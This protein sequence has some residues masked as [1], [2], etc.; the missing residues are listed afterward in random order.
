MDTHHHLVVEIGPDK[1]LTIAVPPQGLRVG[2]SA[3]NDV[4]L[5]DPVMSRFHCRFFFKPGE[6]LWA[7][8]L[9]SANQTLL[10]QAP[11]HAS[12]LRVG[13]RL[14]MGDTT[15]RVMSETSDQQAARALFDAPGGRKGPGK[16]MFRRPAEDREAG[17]HPV[18]ASLLT[19]LF[20]VAALGAGAFVWLRLDAPRPAAPHPVASV[21]GPRSNTL[22]VLYEKVQADDKT[23]FRYYLEL[24]NGELSIQVHD[25]KNQRQVPGRQRRPV[26]AELVDQLGDAIEAADFFSLND[27]YEGVAAAAVWDLMDL[28]VTLDRRTHRVR[29]L[30]TLEPEAFQAVREAVETF[31]QNELGLAALALSPEKLLELARAAAL[32]GRNLYDKRSIKHDNL[33]SAIRSLR[34]VEWYL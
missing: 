23:I 13:D 15:L 14:A 18:L 28:T 31:G 29:V 4:V 32:L 3:N 11:M 34:E 8:D 5:N 7:E 1:G 33:S 9:G 16:M 22:S 26:A 12:R 20:L 19:V 25:L 24:E 10:N 17:R 27:A 21:S 30:N 6:G 2:R